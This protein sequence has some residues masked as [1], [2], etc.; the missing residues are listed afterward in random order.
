MPGART[1]ELQLGIVVVNDRNDRRRRSE[2]Y[3]TRLVPLPKLLLTELHRKNA[4]LELGGPRSGQR[5][6]AGGHESKIRIPKSEFGYN[7]RAACTS[8]TDFLGGID[9]HSD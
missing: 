3:I 6:P 5:E 7:L 4:E 1:A 2:P 9:D 8:A